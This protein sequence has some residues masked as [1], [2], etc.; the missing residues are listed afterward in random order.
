MKGKSCHAASPAPSATDAVAE[1][2]KVAV[3]PWSPNP[4]RERKTSH[5]NINAT[6]HAVNAGNPARSIEQV[7]SAIAKHE[8]MSRR[9]KRRSD[10]HKSQGK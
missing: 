6:P 2:T 3:L 7:T 5:S 9:R 10:A 4:V 1:A 8:D